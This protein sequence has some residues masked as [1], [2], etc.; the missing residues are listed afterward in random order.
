[1]PTSVTSQP[2]RHS[3]GSVAMITI[4]DG[5]QHL[6]LGQ[7]NDSWQAINFVGGHREHGESYRDCL[8]REI[9]EE[10]GLLLTRDFRIPAEPARAIEY[11]AVSRRTDEW[12]RYHL[13]LY[14]VALSAGVSD[15]LSLNPR[16]HWL[17]EQ[18]IDAMVTDTGI[19]ISRTMKRVFDEARLW[20]DQDPS[21]D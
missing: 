15:R 9:T 4:L 14:S 12:T 11:T 7:W 19:P 3:Y 5:R 2:T 17:T 18:Q 8:I 21:V 20:L 13:S 10:L 16:N 1:M 6:W